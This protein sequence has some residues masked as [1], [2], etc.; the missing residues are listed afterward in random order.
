MKKPPTPTSSGGSLFDSS[1]RSVIYFLIASSVIYHQSAFHFQVSHKIRDTQLRRYTNAQVNVIQAHCPFNDLHTCDKLFISFSPIEDAC[2]DDLL[3]EWIVTVR[4]SFLKFVPAHLE[5]QINQ[6]VS[7]YLFQIVGYVTD[8]LI[9]RGTLKAPDP[10]KP[11]T[12]GVFYVE[13][14]YI[15]P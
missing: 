7:G 2:L 10:G 12:D 13:S 15:D 4:K 14:R 11:L 3:T 9:R 1:D 6:W 8:E 5:D